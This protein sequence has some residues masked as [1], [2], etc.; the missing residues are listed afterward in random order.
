MKKKHQ[1]NTSWF[2]SNREYSFRVASDREYSSRVA[3]DRDYSS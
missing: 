3:S 1:L 2:T